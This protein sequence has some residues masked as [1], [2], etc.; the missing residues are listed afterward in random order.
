MEALD[1]MGIVG[2]NCAFKNYRQLY[3]VI[4]ENAEKLKRASSRRKQSHKEVLAALIEEAAH[5]EDWSLQEKTQFSKEISGS[6]DINLIVTPKVRKF[7][8]ESDVKCID[9]WKNAK[10]VYWGIVQNCRVAETKQGRKYCRVSLYGDSGVSYLC[11]LWNYVESKDTVFPE[12]SLLVGN[13]K[14]SDFGLS[15]SFGRVSILE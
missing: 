5:L 6:V 10:D 12:S 7:F 11:F 1:D 15:A 4:I 8:A 3:Y 14:K 9:D 2:P 13:F